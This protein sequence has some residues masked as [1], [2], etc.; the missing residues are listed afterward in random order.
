MPSEPIDPVLAALA[1]LEAVLGQ[2]A[3]RNDAALRRASAIR[4]LRARGLEYSAIVPMEERPLVVELL[5]RTLSDLSDASSNLRK[6]EARALYSEGLTM[7][8]IAELFGVTR[9]RIGAILRGDDLKGPGRPRLLRDLSAVI[10]LVSGS[11]Q[12]LPLLEVFQ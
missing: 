5:T 10:A 1:K 7:A 6:V 2:I 9:Q 11:A 8:E 12:E 3:E 4:R